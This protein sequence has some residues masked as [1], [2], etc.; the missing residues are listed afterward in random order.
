[1]SLFKPSMLTLAFISAGVGSFTVNAADETKLAAAKDVEVIEVR[2]IRG[3]LIRAQAVKMDS[4]SIVE[5]ISAEDIGKLPDTSVAE[6]LARLPGVTGERRNGRTSGLSVRG[7]NENYVASSLNGRELLGMG[8][9]RGVEFD[10]YPTEIITSIVV[11]KTPEAGLLSQGIGGTID[12]QTVDPLS[13]KKAMAFNASFEQNAEDS[14]NPDYDNKGH[15]FSFNFVDQYADD[16]IGLA[17]VLSSQETPRQ[18]DQ[19]GSWGFS[20]VNLDPDS[21]SGMADDT[22][23]ATATDQILNGQD[24]YVRS[25]LMERDSVAAVI[26]FAPTDQFKLQFDA[27]YIQF[28]ENDVKRGMEEA[29]GNYTITEISNGRVS[30]GYTDGFHS[31]IRNDG[32]QKKADLTTFGLNM[33]YQ[34]NEDWSLALDLSSSDVEKTLTDVESYSGVG[35]SNIAGRPAAARSFEMTSEG[36]LYSPHP[37][38]P[39]VDYTDQDLI[40]LAGPQAW[41]GGMQPFTQFTDDGLNNAAFAQDGFINI[42]DFEEELHSVRFEVKGALELGFISA[43]ET[44]INYSERKKSKF[45]NGKYLT[46]PTFPSH[47]PIPEVLGIADLSFI[48]LGG[49]LAYDSLGLV[50]S[51]YYSSIDANLIDNAR[52]GDSYT[53][54][55]EIFTLYTKL[56]IDSELGN[57]YVSGNVGLQLVKSDQIGTGYSTTTVDQFTQAT[58]IVDSDSYTDLLPTLNL[59]FEVAEN[60]FIR[61]SAA[62]VLSRPRID[63]LRPNSQVTF[64]FNDVTIANT[65]PATGPWSSN[66]GNSKLKPLEANQFDLSYENY[67]EDD[68]YFAAS[69][70]FKDLK[71]WHRTSTVIADYTDSYIPGYHQSSTGEAP[72]ILKGIETS[73]Q[74]GLQGFVR[75]YE[76]QASVPLRIA[77]DMLDGFGITMSGTFLDGRLDVD[78]STGADDRIPGLSEESYSVTFYYEMNG[79]EARISGTK[80]GEYLTETRGGSLSLTPTTGQAAELWDAQIGYDF[81]DSDIQTLKGL[82]ITLQAQNI[83]DE[84]TIESTDEGYVTRHSSFGANYS[85]GLNYKF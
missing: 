61:T 22:V 73:T 41:G 57:V 29:M 76:L 9:N 2:G 53:I 13:A 58:P 25:A 44:G 40:K 8:D 45:N 3:S 71:N 5:V 68:G 49:V 1:M 62:K 18:E 24:S 67:F 64:A 35:R 16:T 51:G 63:N 23:T 56:D 34:L 4:K 80:R 31:V 65:D 43:I 6:S 10:L 78:T 66:S 7:F 20:P 55:E 33:E 79:F 60:Q 42:A 74:D 15:R 17:L 39:Y 69:F 14:G 48:G 83:T 82:R 75:G 36:V 54:E 38:T 72:A 77:H 12:L 19:F 81:S 47:G 85:L 84:S 46:A 59:S 27:L 32:Q 52:F 37:D 70:F 28:E 26:E 21:R 11:S 30:K 50:N